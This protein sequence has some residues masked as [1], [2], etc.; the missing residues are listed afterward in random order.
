[1]I[2][3]PHQK[4]YYNEVKEYGM[5]GAWDSHRR[6]GKPTVSWWKDTLGRLKH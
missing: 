5:G 3:I 2:C 4:Y 6:E 1:M